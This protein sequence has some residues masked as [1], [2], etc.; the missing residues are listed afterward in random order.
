MRIALVILICLLLSVILNGCAITQPSQQQY[1]DLR[2]EYANSLLQSVRDHKIT[3]AE[4]NR[5]WNEFERDYWKGEAKR[6]E[7]AEVRRQ[8][9]RNFSANPF[10]NAAGDYYICH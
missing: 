2:R 9:E 1:P 8:A 10:C 6:M 7:D 4:A 3:E 5:R